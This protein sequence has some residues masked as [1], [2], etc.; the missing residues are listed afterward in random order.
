MIINLMPPD[1]KEAILY[2]RHNAKLISWI[3]GVGIGVIILV[4]IAGAGIFYLKQDS[5]STQKSIDSSKVA[6]AAQNEAETFKR[7][8]EIGEN[9]NLVVE[10]LSDEIVFSKLLQ[11]I[12]EVMPSGT[13][14]QDLSLTSDFKGGLT[15]RI[16]AVSYEAGTQAHV[17]L[18]DKNN[19]IFQKADLINLSCT[20]GEN[21]DPQYPCQVEIKALFNQ[22]DNPFLLLNQDKESPQ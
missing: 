3:T 5:K 20:S 13:I 18:R 22:E 16:G 7:V 14:L 10:V 21:A 1:K 9:L 11:E 8:Q 17:N 12:G 15:L 4:L 19:G 6:L 2:S